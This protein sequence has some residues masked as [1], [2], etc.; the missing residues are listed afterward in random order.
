[1]RSLNTEDIAF[2]TLFNA[3]EL[4]SCQTRQLL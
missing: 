2:S 1:V 3:Y 4:G